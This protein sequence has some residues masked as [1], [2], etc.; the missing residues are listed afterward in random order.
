MKSS[1]LLLHIV[2]RCVQGILR[3]AAMNQLGSNLSSGQCQIGNLNGTLIVIVSH[4][5]HGHHASRICNWTPPQIT[6]PN[7]AKGSCPKLRI[8]ENYETSSQMSNTMWICHEALWPAG[9]AL[10]NTTSTNIRAISLEAVGHSG[11]QEWIAFRSHQGRAVSEPC[12]LFSSTP[13][14]FSLNFLAP[15]WMV[16]T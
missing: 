10:S 11:Q 9:A 12:G 14:R 5:H 3:K 2:L 6:D 1:R 4:G 8:S 16:V 15:L 7:F 13:D